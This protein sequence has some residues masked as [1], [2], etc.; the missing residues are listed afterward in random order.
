M[1][2]IVRYWH[3]LFL[4]W[5]IWYPACAQFLFCFSR[6]QDCLVS[7][8]LVQRLASSLG[9]CLPQEWLGWA[10]VC[11]PSWFFEC[12][13]VNIWSCTT[14]FLSPSPPPLFL[15][16]RFFY[17]VKCL[18][19]DLLLFAAVLMELAAQSSKGINKDIGY[20]PEELLPI[21]LAKSLC[22]HIS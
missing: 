12:R 5:S 1:S 17:T 13:I 8:V 18:I 10:H 11:T 3:F 6:G 15:C 9:L 16:L 2:W 14:S 22:L 20:I 19:A 4:L 7:L 21:R